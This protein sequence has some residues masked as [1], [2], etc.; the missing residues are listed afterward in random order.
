MN[1]NDVEL[2]LGSGGHY[3][4]YRVNSVAALRELLGNGATVDWTLNWLFLSS[5]G[6]HGSYET[7]DEAA[8]YLAEGEDSS[9]T[10][11][12]VQPRRVQVY[13]GHVPVRA[14]DI[15][16]LR[17]MVRKTLAGVAKSQEGNV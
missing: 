9:I 13:Y 2:Q 12:L 8:E 6:V 4:M 11:L 14:D 5:S 7:L 10:V 3:S 1:V 15:P 17:E 16:W